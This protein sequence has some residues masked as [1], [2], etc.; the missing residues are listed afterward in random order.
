MPNGC[1]VHLK[2]LARQDMGNIEHVQAVQKHIENQR[3]KT[4][5]LEAEIARLNTFC[6]NQINLT[7]MRY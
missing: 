1:E 5:S 4:E 3:L 7:G 6:W 2:A